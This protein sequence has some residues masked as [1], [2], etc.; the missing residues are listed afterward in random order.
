MQSPVEPTTISLYDTDYQRWLAATVGQL[1]SRDFDHLDLENLIE[2]IESL[3]KR[4]KRSLFSYLM[5]L[6]EHLLKLSYWTEERE[7]NFRGWDLEVTNFRLKIQSLLKDSPSLYSY[8]KQRFEA[9]YS[10]GRKLFLK[11]SSLESKT[12]P[13][14]PFFSLEQ[15]LDDEWLPWMPDQH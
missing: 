14:T 4:D 5:R 13:E 8:L 10:N 3:G 7:R 15:A 12:V 1:Q 11:A 9:E 2:E 6:C